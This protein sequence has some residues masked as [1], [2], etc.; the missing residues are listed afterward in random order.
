MASN[1]K[2]Q[3]DIF[4]IPI[5]IHRSQT[6]HFHHPYKATYYLNKRN[7]SNNAKLPCQK[8][9][10]DPV[11]LNLLHSFSDESSSNPK[12]RQIC[13]NALNTCQQPVGDRFLL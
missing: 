6:Q 9:F 11:T 4:V 13:S 10:A 7:L 8:S 1:L 12:V 2:N 3:T 5:A